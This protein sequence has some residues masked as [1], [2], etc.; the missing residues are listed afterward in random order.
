MA[1][2]EFSYVI[3]DKRFRTY[4]KV[5]FTDAWTAGRQQTWE[6]SVLPAG[7]YLD[8]LIF[9]VEGTYRQD[10]NGSDAVDP[11]HLVDIIDNVEITNG[12]NTHLRL[13]MYMISQDYKLLS[14]S[15]SIWPDAIAASATGSNVDTDFSFAVPFL[16]SNPFLKR[17]NDTSYPTSL[18][19]D[20]NLTIHWNNDDAMNGDA[21]SAVQNATCRILSV[22]SRLN[23]A[24][25][26]PE[27][28]VGYLTSAT[29]DFRLS[30]GNYQHVW[31]TAFT[32]TNKLTQTSIYAEADGLDII[33]A[34]TRLD[35]LEVMCAFDCRWSDD[36]Q[37][38]PLQGDLL[39]KN[40]PPVA[41]GDY[42]YHWLPII[43]GVWEGKFSKMVRVE[44]SFNFQITSTG[45]IT[46]KIGYRRYMNHTESGLDARAKVMGFGPGSDAVPRTNRRS[47]GE[48]DLS[49]SDLLPVRLTQAPPA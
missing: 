46:K 42:A 4:R 25:I 28:E 2:K 18:M 11:A 19:Q 7:E 39:D 44:H 47:L 3:S 14:G 33:A 30:R 37:Q 20:G 13:P 26:P 16:Y 38:I 10:G 9:S 36:E 32:K 8:E 17:F 24:V 1:K 31:A 48:G 23:R 29:D 43:F 22:T 49:L 27:V 15:N 21:V 41:A 45:A 12:S 6:L 40:I 35:E 34:G 5:L